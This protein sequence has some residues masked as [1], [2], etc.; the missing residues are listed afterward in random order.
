MIAMSTSQPIRWTPPWR[1]QEEPKPV[2]LL[3]APSVTERE[4]LE[5]ELSGEHRA[6]IVYGFQLRAAFAAGIDSLI[7][8]TAPD[9]AARLKE[10]SAQQ[11]ALKDGESLAD[12]EIALLE[13]AEAVLIEHYPAY[14]SLIAQQQRREALAPIVAFQKWCVGVENLD[15]PFARDWSGVKPEAMAAIDPLELRVAGRTAYN[16]AYAGQHLGN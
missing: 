14:R 7:G 12:D 4:I 8:E 16:L 2:Y 5:G 15:V 11:A 10:L 6:G 3:R 13:A 9:D 1:E